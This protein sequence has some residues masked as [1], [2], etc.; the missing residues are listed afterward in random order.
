MRNDSIISALGIRAQIE[1]EYPGWLAAEVSRVKALAAPPAYPNLLYMPI[2]GPY[3]RK[4]PIMPPSSYSKPE[5]RARRRGFLI[6]WNHRESWR[7]PPVM[8]TQLSTAVPTWF[9]K[10]ETPMGF[11]TGGSLV[12]YYA[13]DEIYR[14]CRVA[15][16]GV[17]AICGDEYF[18]M[19]C[20]RWY[21]EAR[22]GRFWLF[23]DA[24]LGWVKKRK[25]EELTG[26][27]ADALCFFQAM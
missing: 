15:H 10:M 21:E 4:L 5:Q 23:A 9:A 19:S 27:D 1:D 13:R 20:N 6:S 14:S 12:A 7:L 24:L 8:R 25:P 22:D 18:V 11:T 3:L 17:M 26:D 16:S 2:P